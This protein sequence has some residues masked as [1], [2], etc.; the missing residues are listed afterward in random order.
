MPLSGR[1]VAGLAAGLILVLAAAATAVAVVY[2]HSQ[3]TSACSSSW[4]ESTINQM[5]TLVPRGAHV[6]YAGSRHRV[7]CAGSMG[8]VQVEF[9]A[10]VPGKANQHLAPKAWYQIRQQVERRA[11]RDGWVEV[12]GRANWIREINGTE[13][14]CNIGADYGS[15]PGT[16][17]LYTLSCAVSDGALPWG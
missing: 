14:F 5:R 9:R 4:K 10:K 7:D 8:G 1:W 3:R 2:T 11:Q 13:T 17:D 15:G 6:T 16:N 12:K